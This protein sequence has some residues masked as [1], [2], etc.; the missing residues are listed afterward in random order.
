MHNKAAFQLLFCLLLGAICT[1]LV[2]HELRPAIADIRLPERGQVELQLEL[3]LESV[4]AGI[5][6]EHRDTDNA[7]NARFYRSLRELSASELEKR[8]RDFEPGLR[9]LLTLEF[10]AGPT[11]LELH[12]VEIPP[13]GDTR[14]SRNSRIV[15]RAGVP[16]GT[17]R[18]RWRFAEA[19]GD[20]LVRFHPPGTGTARS[21]WLQAGQSSDWIDLGEIAPPRGALEVSLEY[22]AIGYRHIVPL[23][24]DHMLFVLGLFLLGNRLRP[25]IWQVSA[26]TVAHTLTLAL[27]MFGVLSLS[28]AVVEPLIALSIVYVGVENLYSARPRPWR[29]VVVFGF[30]LLHGMGFAGILT[31]IGLEPAET[32]NA[33]ISFNLGVE[34]GQL[35]V[36]L[37]AWLL[38]WPL[39]R[40]AAQ[41]RRWVSL[42]GSAA[43]AAVGAWWCWQRIFAG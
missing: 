41:F 39:L 1:E 36:L 14:L 40:D 27:T 26:F 17:T 22:L 23:G 34:L 16:A 20:S 13:V 25:L 4:L 8:L 2:A 42:P 7:P 18:L 9:N 10:D 35:S 5:G 24:L 6:A 31:S 3:N 15:Y 33:L 30:G 28:P 21:Y 38:C 29:V 11:D 43:I 12:A 32:F 19:Y 37:V